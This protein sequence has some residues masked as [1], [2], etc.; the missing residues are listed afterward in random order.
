MFLK[1]KRLLWFWI[2]LVLL[3]L[4]EV[5]RVWRSTLGPLLSIAELLLCLWLGLISL[6]SLKSLNVG[7]EANR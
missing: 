2:E 6:S 3:F 7:M 4:V 5:C 1:L